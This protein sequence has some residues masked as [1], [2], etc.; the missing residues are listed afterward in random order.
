MNR[1]LNRT[2]VI[3]ALLGGV[4]LLNLVLPIA[5]L[6]VKSNP[7]E[8]LASLRQ[9]GALS[10]LKVS[11]VS[12]GIAVLAMAL[13]GVPLGYLLARAKLPF[14]RLWIGLVFLPM[15]VP[16]LA[17]GILLLRLFGPYGVIGH[18]FDAHN[19]ALTNNI[20]GIVLVQIFVAAP[21][22]VASSLASFSNVDRELEAAAG[23]LGDSAWQVFTRVSLP[24]AWP[25][26]A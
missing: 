1:L 5:N 22:V 23:T 21:F 3:F 10:A 16:D 15:V 11:V 18:P 17:G 14:K 8:V 2:F 24:L 6:L 4:L 9:P 26:I 20:V 12:S 19:L 25:G 7:A 13:M